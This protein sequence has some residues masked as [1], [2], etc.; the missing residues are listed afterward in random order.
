IMLISS[1]E[2]DARVDFTIKYEIL[3]PCAH[4]GFHEAGNLDNLGRVA[5]STSARP[6]AETGATSRRRWQQ[7]MRRGMLATTSFAVL[8]VAAVST[9]AAAPTAIGGQAAALAGCGGP[10]KQG[11]SLVVGHNY[12][13]D[14]LNPL[15]PSNNGEILV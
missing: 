7:A 1:I 12:E 6:A 15:A 10:A 8:A 11:G 13:V 9:T 5:R 2:G 4:A 3:A 14:N